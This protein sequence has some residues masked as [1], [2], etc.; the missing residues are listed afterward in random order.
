MWNDL[1]SFALDSRLNEWIAATYWLWPVLE[2]LHFIGLSLLFGGLL[3]V[4]LRMLGWFASLQQLRVNKLLP[5]VICG[6][7]INLITGVLFYFGDPARYSA[8]IA[9]KIKMGLIL[10]AG[11]N[12]LFH[13]VLLV[14]SARDQTEVLSQPFQ[15]ISAV[16]SLL[17]WLGVLLF[18]RLIPYIGTG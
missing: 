18:G 13:H 9:F 15:K 8:N 14:R 4:D 2:I 5:L 7:A 3:I 6:F 17:A 11:C 1:A 10:L 16:I 12:A